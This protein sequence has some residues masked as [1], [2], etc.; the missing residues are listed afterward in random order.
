MNLKAGA[1][2]AVIVAAG[3]G[4]GGDDTTTDTTTPPSTSAPP[5]SPNPAPAPPPQGVTPTPAPIAAP[6]PPVA[7]PSP[8]PAPSDPPPAPQPEAITAGTLN[9]ALRFQTQDV[10]LPAPNHAVGYSADSNTPPAYYAQ[11]NVEGEIPYATYATQT[12]DRIRPGGSAP[13]LPT[14]VQVRME[15][16]SMP[17]FY[18]RAYVFV[19]YPHTLTV[20]LENS[21]GTFGLTQQRYS[22]NT[23]LAKW[24]MSG[25][26]ITLALHSD[27][28]PDSFRLCWH[29][30]LDSI[31]L[32]RLSCGVFDKAGGR[33]IGMHLEDIAPGET[34]VRTWHGAVR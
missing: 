10:L 21:A 3:C 27:S 33:Q 4:G 30:V 29:V 23:D 7:V 15:F 5:A 26:R 32:N 11:Y 1:L 14:L 20:T 12:L 18:P 8:T 13:E 19:G 2:L 17:N 31:L 25:G 22:L 28:N 16:A 9:F 6:S 34:F 24:E